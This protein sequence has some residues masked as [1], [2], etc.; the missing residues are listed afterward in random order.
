MSRN[1][2]Y[3]IGVDGGGTKTI[4][5]IAGLQGSVLAETQG[6]P[7]NFQIVGVEEA[8]RNILDLI[9]TCCH[10]VGCNVSE[11]GS[12]VAGL[13]GAGR[14][15]D[16][17]KICDGIQ[18]AAQNRG[19]YLQEVRIESDAR[20]A[21]EGA[22]HGGP[23]IVLIGGTGSIAFSK[24]AKGKIHRV[25][26]WGRLIGDEGSGY[27]IGQEGIR[28]IAKMID[29]R[30][31]KTSLAALLAS[32]LGLRSQEDII[33]AVYSENLELSTIAPLVIEAANRKDAIALRIIAD[34]AIELLETIRTILK[35]MR[36]KSSTAR[37]KI[38]LAFIGGVL[39]SENAYSNRVKTLIRAKLPAVSVQ[40]PLERP[41]F[42]AVL[43]ALGTRSMK[44][45]MGKKMEMVR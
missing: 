27:Y 6:G 4:A 14:G 16:Q 2:A 7:S 22:F 8:A 11:I 42:G 21:L 24:D 12:V 13:A 33:Q 36:V 23:G 26:G 37:N 40:Q 5:Q 1:A 44:M 31:K 17:K 34:A 29:G 18:N 15:A 10:T 20:I 45:E 28:A 32:R 39:E 3:V 30:G 35:A 9:E 25:G 41:V 19:M 38:P 43:L